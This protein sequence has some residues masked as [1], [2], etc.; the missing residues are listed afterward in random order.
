MGAR[1]LETIYRAALWLFP[2]AFREEYG[3]DLAQLVRDRRAELAEK[4]WQA[5]LRF[6]IRVLEDVAIEAVAERASRLRA[7]AFRRPRR[8]KGV[9]NPSAAR[10]KRVADSPEPERRASAARASRAK[11]E[12]SIERREPW[13]WGPTALKGDRV[14]IDSFRQDLAYALRSIARAKA[15]TA[16]VVLTF[17]LAIGANTAIFS[18]L[19][20]VLLE[21]LPFGRP[22]A[23]VALW[24]SKPSEGVVKSETSAGLF[25]DWRAKNQTLEDLTAWTFDT[26][27]L[28]GD[29]ESV[30]L[31]AVLVYPNFF[32]VLELDPLFGRRFEMDDAPPGPGAVKGR[33]SATRG[34]AAILSHAL[35]RDR[36][37]SDPAVVG[38]T[39]RIDGEPLLVVAVM[40]PDVAAPTSS[41]DLWIP[42]SLQSP[43][44]WER[45]VRRYGVYGRLRHG[46]TEAQAQ[47]DLSRIAAELRS[48]EYKDLY[49]GWD[50]RVVPLREEIVGGSRP[51]LLTAFA[52]VAVVL[53]IACVNI[54]NMLLARSADRRRE[55]A[56]RAAMG[57]G[58]GRIVVQL[59]TESLF[60]AF[61]GGALGVGVARA[62][63]ELLLRFQPGI[64]PRVQE[65]SLDAWAV[66][67]AALVTLACGLAFGLA[68]AF[69]A[70]RIDLQ[71]SLQQSGGLGPTSGHGLSRAR[72]ALVAAQLAL[73]TVLVSGAGLLTRTSSSSGG[74]IRDS[75]PK[76]ALLFVCS[77]TR[78]DTI[79]RKRSPSTSRD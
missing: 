25:L 43:I 2:R 17:A 54:A 14:M 20:G 27:V 77:S 18:V 12:A 63:H 45:H 16:L 7:F 28:Q 67:F 23:L 4:P 26:V 10:A 30:A 40:R 76:G 21:P 53:L 41:A 57:A 11:S 58:R 47:Q 51:T 70:L 61:L 31:N 19:R 38:R 69:H 73:A 49:E 78:G 36:F 75:T 60:L 33:N 72:A 66:A 15:F 32:S 39:L 5:R 55:I 59:L 34:K 52:A 65:L 6:W 44:R 8:R 24:E 71:G 37:G 79:R 1:W 22:E 56:L 42:V 62:G 35:W 13:G 3:E 64:V 50:A 48:G 46:A 9:L 68:P 29:E 74:S